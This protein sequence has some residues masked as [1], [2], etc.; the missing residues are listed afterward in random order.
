MA[1][2][3]GDCPRQRFFAGYFPTLVPD[4]PDGADIAFYGLIAGLEVRETRTAQHWLYP[5]RII[6]E[7]Y[8]A[9]VE[10]EIF[11]PLRSLNELEFRRGLNRLRADLGRSI[12]PSTITLAVLESCGPAR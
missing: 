5:N 2:G 4:L 9:M 3:N 8:V 10:T 1:S 7:D 6:D 11:A 12:P